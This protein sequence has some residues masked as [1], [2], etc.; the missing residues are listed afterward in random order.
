ME[1]TSLVCPRLCCPRSFSFSVW[2]QHRTS[3][4][5]TKHRLRHQTTR[6]LKQ[7]RP[8]LCL[9]VVISKTKICLQ[10]LELSCFYVF[11]WSS[12]VF[13][14]R[15][16]LVSPHHLQGIVFINFGTIFFSEKPVQTVEVKWSTSTRV[17]I[18]LFVGIW[19]LDTLGHLQDTY[20]ISEMS[21]S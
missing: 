14:G 21:F 3:E 12:I 17:G 6:L 5:L 20:Q 18:L 11:F 2:K 1:T 16:D 10:K 19:C 8:R 15:L 4:T 13:S 9:I 7:H